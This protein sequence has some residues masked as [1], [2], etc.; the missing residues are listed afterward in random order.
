LRQIPTYWNCRACETR[1][2]APLVNFQGAHQPA[3][4]TWLRKYR[5]FIIA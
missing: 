3:S 2:P 5:I 4:H 1:F